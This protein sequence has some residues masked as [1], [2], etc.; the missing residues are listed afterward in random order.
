MLLRPLLLEPIPQRI[1]RSNQLFEGSRV[2]DD[3][4]AEG[5]SFR[6]VHLRCDSP[7]GVVSIHTSR[8][9]QPSLGDVSWAIDHHDDVEIHHRPVLGSQ[10]GDREQDGPILVDVQ[11]TLS[12]HFEA[13]GRMGNGVEV[14]QGRSV[15]E[16]AGCEG[17]P[18]E[19]S[20]D[21]QNSGA[22]SLDERLEH[23]RAGLHDV[24]GDLVGVDERGTALNQEIGHRGLP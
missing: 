20:V 11:P 17:E 23:G 19:V 18:I 6:T 8:F 2:V 12:D 13:D 16:G 9:H 7:I 15:A 5:N 21:T 4:V 10:E 24:P 14:G 3:S 1:G 22:E